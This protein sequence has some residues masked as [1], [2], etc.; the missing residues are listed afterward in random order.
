M[1]SVEP[2]GGISPFS[3]P[4]PGRCLSRFDGLRGPV[5][6]S[7]VEILWVWL[8]VRFE[9]EKVETPLPASERGRAGP[10]GARLSYFS[11]ALFDARRPRALRGP[12]YE[13]RSFVA[14]IERG[15]CHFMTRHE[16]LRCSDC[17]SLISDK[18]ETKTGFVNV[19]SVV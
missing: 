3:N 13:P 5:G 10:L 14:R 19:T 1:G 7:S 18:F 12:A 17:M 15:D 4:P 11:L 6:L 16:V 9:R 2:A 8:G